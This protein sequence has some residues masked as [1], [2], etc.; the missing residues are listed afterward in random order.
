MISDTSSAASTSKPVTKSSNKKIE[1]S[2][3]SEEDQLL[4][5]IQNS[6]REI[7]SDSTENSPTHDIN[8]DSN[9]GDDGGDD[10][11]I[12]IGFE[13]DSDV[14]EVKASTSQSW[15]DYL[16]DENGETLLLFDNF[17]FY[18]YQSSVQSCYRSE[19]KVNSSFTRW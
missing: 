8:G 14:V 5:A 10:G 6:L 17:F 15:N 2:V 11:V 18:F 1:A 13:S 9:D 7:S 19:S 3:L 12:E 16:G 4:L